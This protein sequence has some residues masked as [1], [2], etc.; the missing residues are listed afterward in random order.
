MHELHTKCNVCSQA[1]QTDRLI[2]SLCKEQKY[3]KSYNKMLTL[4]YLTEH[5]GTLLVLINNSCLY[6]NEIY[7]TISEPLANTSCYDVRTLISS[8]SHYASKTISVIGDIINVI[9]FQY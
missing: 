2:V 8:S 1:S 9:S 3:I 6:S 4:V 5:I 7:K